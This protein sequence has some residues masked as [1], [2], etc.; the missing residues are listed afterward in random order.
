MNQENIYILEDVINSIGNCLAA[1]VLP[2][3]PEVHLECIKQNL[4]KYIEQLKDIY[5][6]ETQENPW[7]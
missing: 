3:P 7:E 6:N 2:M 1:L 5:I 4:D